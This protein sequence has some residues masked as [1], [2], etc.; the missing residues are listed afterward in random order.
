MGDLSKAISEVSVQLK[1]KIDE[2]TREKEYHQVYPAKSSPPLIAKK[3][4]CPFLAIMNH[5]LTQVRPVS[6]SPV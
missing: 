5:G 1:I 3:S 4:V 2:I 6:G